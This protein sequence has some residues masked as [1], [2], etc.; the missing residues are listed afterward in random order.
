MAMVYSEPEKQFSDYVSSYYDALN[1]TDG[2]TFEVASN[3]S[4]ESGLRIHGASLRLGWRH[5]LSFD[6]QGLDGV[7]NSIGYRLEVAY[8]VTVVID[9]T[10]VLE[11]GSNVQ[12][13]VLP[14]DGLKHRV[15]I[16]FTTEPSQDPMESVHMYLLPNSKQ[17]V[18]NW[19]CFPPYSANITNLSLDVLEW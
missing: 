19:Y 1:Q 17:V 11:K 3:R 4:R 16:S 7:L 10:V 14:A 5:R 18:D 6:I 12:S 9:G 8:D 15:A 2:V 13:L